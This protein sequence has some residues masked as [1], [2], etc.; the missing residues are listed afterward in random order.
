MK[1]KKYI[2]YFL[3][4][5]IFSLAF[6]K[7]PCEEVKAFAGDSNPQLSAIIDG[8]EK[9]YAVPGFSARF[10]QT[11]TLK[12]MDITDTASGRLLI[13]RPGMMR[14]EYETPDRQTIIS[15]GFQ[16]WIYRPEDNQVMIGKAPDFF[17]DGKGASF[18]SDITRMRR[19]FTISLEKNDKDNN[20]VLK[21]LPGKKALDLAAIYLTIARE[22]FEVVRIVTYNSFGDETR[23]DLADIRFDPD[24]ENA[25]FSFAAPE[26]AEILQ[27]E[28]QP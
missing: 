13:K 17:G 28:E 11:S 18:L 23:I 10:F 2:F 22:T 8:I 16:L 19:N 5:S 27:L 6:S 7:S 24:L 12:D 25:L 1:L 26:G 14:W 9:R 21:L 20:P 4:F 15:D 3:F